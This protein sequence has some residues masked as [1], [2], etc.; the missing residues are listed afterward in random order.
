MSRLSDVGE[1]KMCQNEVMDCRREEDEINHIE[2][3]GCALRGCVEVATHGAESPGSGETAL[4]QCVF[5]A[6]GASLY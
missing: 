4:R 6:A 2:I 5:R 1:L 3:K